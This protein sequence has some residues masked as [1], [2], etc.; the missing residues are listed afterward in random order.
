MLSDDVGIDAMRI[1][2]DDFAKDALESSCVERRAAADDAIAGQSRQSPDEVG[3]SVERIGNGDDVA[4]EA[5][6]HEFLNCRAYHLTCHLENGTADDVA[7]GIA[8]EQVLGC[9]EA[10]D[11][12]IGITAVLVFASADLHVSAHVFDTVAQVHR[13]TDGLGRIDIHEDEV[14][15]DSLIDESVAY[16][17][18]HCTDT[19]DSDLVSVIE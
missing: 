4:I 6:T 17:R 2:V 8:L 7:F 11:G 13:F 5:R 3:D 18:T 1:D 12:N 9:A 14:V 19:D 10:D 16:G 15:A